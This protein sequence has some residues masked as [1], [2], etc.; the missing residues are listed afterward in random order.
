MTDPIV[1]AVHAD[2]IVQAVL[3][4]PGDR[5]SGTVTTQ[6]GNVVASPT[7]TEEEDRGTAGQRA[8]N[9]VWESTQ[10]QIAL[11]VIGSSLL[12]SVVLAV[13]GP[14]LGIPR[15]LQ[16]AAAVFLFGVANLVTGFYFGR[17]NHT[18]IGGVQQGR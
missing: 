1:D 12:V 14:I 11:S 18:K 9:M 6:A 8:V 7:S 15:E 17:T 2:P 4:A 13:G 16:L 5:R 3:A 10:R